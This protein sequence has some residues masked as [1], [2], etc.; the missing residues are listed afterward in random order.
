MGRPLTGS[1]AA[2]TEP[3][4]APDDPRAWPGAATLERAAL[5]RYFTLLLG[6]A[7]PLTGSFAF[8]FVLRHDWADAFPD[9]VMAGVSLAC[10]AW[11]W[12]AASAVQPMRVLIVA[13]TDRAHSPG[14]R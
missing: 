12:R 2:A 1:A 13:R 5:R 10:G 11:A 3:T 9:L 8:T 14:P 4:D 6:F 7:L